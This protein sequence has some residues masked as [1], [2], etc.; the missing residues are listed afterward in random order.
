MLKVEPLKVI[1][2]MS[3]SESKSIIARTLDFE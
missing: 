3:Q 2:K 1:K